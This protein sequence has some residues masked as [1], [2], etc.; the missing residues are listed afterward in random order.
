MDINVAI[1]NVHEILLRRCER[2][3]QYVSN[4]SMAFTAI[5]V[6]K[7]KWHNI[8]FQ[9]MYVL[10]SS[11]IACTH[12]HKSINGKTLL[13]SWMFFFCTFASD[14]IC[15]VYFIYVVKIFKCTL[16]W[17]VLLTKWGITSLKGLKSNAGWSRLTISIIAGC[18]LLNFGSWCNSQI[19]TQSYM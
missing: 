16:L 18:K 7:V 19:V 14:S 10:A 4:G 3:M 5:S 6:N 13:P 15:R 9:K 2:M 17:E 1:I 12:S 8:S 11:A